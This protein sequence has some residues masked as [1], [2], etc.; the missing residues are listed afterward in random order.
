MRKVKY[1][2]GV[3]LDG[4]I[5]G[6]GNTLDWLERATRGVKGEDFG[7][8]KLFAEIDTVLMGRKTWEISQKLG[9]KGNPYK[10]MRCYVFSRTLPAGVRD[11]VEFTSTAPEKLIVSLRKQAGKDVWLCGGGELAR[12]FL[13]QG[14]V[15]EVELGIVPVLLGEGI[16]AFPQGFPEKAL[17]LTG[18][19]EYKGGVV[20]LTYSVG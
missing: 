1:A 11:G 20:G 7:L 3:S 6:I 2:V 9:A 8:K 12:D 16:P 10:G 15:D 19:V 5:A 13:R 18:C 4:Y 17:K 14:L